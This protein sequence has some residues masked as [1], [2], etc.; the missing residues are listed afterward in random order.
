MLT[1]ICRSTGAAPIL[2]ATLTL[3]GCSS[4]APF[5]SADVSTRDMS[6]AA[7]VDGDAAGTR[8]RVSLQGPGGAVTLVG[9]DRL[10]LRAGAREVPMTRD[11]QGNRVADLAPGTVG[12]ALGLSREAPEASVDLAI[13][14]PPLTSLVVPPSAS[15]AAPVAIQW[16]PATGPQKLTLALAGTCLPPI[17]RPLSVDV[18]SYT[19]QPADLSGPS[20]ETCTVTVSLTRQV[21]E[22]STIG[23][24][25]RTILKLNQVAT[26]TFES[27]P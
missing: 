15:R 9:G 10:V 2:V 24:L 21:D 6:L 18:G 1:L 23:L 4:E 5:L 16:T 12:L 7:Y 26:A 20:A 8:V 22:G 25:Q 19:L 13:P 11:E 17:T 14:M 27:T 3:L